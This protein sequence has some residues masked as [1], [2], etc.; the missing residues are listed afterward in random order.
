M[1]A[2]LPR[3]AISSA[4]GGE[5][6]VADIAAAAAD[7]LSVAKRRAAGRMVR[8][9]RR[10]MAPRPD[11]R[12]RVFPPAYADA[13]CGKR[14][15]LHALAGRRGRACHARDGE[16]I[17]IG[18]TTGTMHGKRRKTVVFVDR[19]PLVRFKAADDFAKSGLMVSVIKTIDRKQLHRKNLFPLNTLGFGSSHTGPTSTNPA[20]LKTW[21]SSAPRMICKRWL[22]TR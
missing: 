22:S 13:G 1:G 8:T 4:V 3:R 17:V 2:G 15:C 14:G 10:A 11:R 16:K 20:L 21:S 6:H 9:M 19:R 18:F 7:G 5:V 12:G